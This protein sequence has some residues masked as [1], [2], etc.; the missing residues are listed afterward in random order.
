MT[1]NPALESRELLEGFAE[2]A[3]SSLRELPVQLEGYLAQPQEAE[4]L[5]AVFRVVHSIKGNAGFFGFTAI[6]TFAHAV[7]NALDDVRKQKVKLTAEL[8]R[9]FVES[10]DQ[11]EGLVNGTLDGADT[12]QLDPTQQALLARV[13]ELATESAPDTPES[14]IAAQLTQLAEAIAELDASD[15][16]RVAQRAEAMAEQCRQGRMGDPL[17]REPEGHAE[18]ATASPNAL[19]LATAEFRAG[20]R[21]WT[22]LVRPTLEVFLAMS[23]G[24]FDAPLAQAFLAA[25][26]QLAAEAEQAGLVP[27]AT[28][29]TAA[30]ADF[31]KIYQSPLGMDA[32]LLSIVWDHLCPEYVKLS[33]GA[34]GPVPA[35]TPATTA[36]E[37]APGGATPQTASQTAAGEPAQAAG[38]S[39]DK[40]S[41]RTRFVRVKEDRLDEFRGHV[42]SL[43]ITCELLKDLHSRF[44]RGETLGLLVDEMRQV[45][46]T[47]AAQTQKLQ[48]S[49]VAL[50][51]VSVSGLFAKFPRMARTLATQLG[52]QIDVHLVGEETEVDK[53]LVEDLD[54]PLTHMI[55]NVVDHGIEPPAERTQRGASASGNL[56]LRAE[57]TR[58]HVIIT[59]QDDG[60][61]IDPVRLKAKSVAKGALTQAQADAMSDEEA[62]G[63]IFAP[64]FST[65]EK[66]SEVSGRGV[67]LDVVRTKI[68]EHNGEVT[69]RS[70]VGEGTTFRLEIP[71]R[72]A[73]VVTD[74]LMIRHAQQA[75]V[76]PFEH[77][78]EIAELGPTDLSP[79]QGSQVATIRG[80]SYDAV[81]MGRILDLPDHPPNDSTRLAVLVESKLGKLC[82]LVDAVTGHRQVVVNSVADLLPG[83]DYLSGV[84][85]LGGGHLAL[86]LS[87]EELI[88]RLLSRAGVDHCR[89]Q[90][91]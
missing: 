2:E 40:H 24:R 74:G 26:D 79:V 85:Q 37:L 78:R 19:S 91:R 62:V 25:A 80:V 32:T 63:L 60:R 35:P 16:P 57:A 69:V 50:Q 41:N 90:T 76:I 46:Y 55:R 3:L 77:V 84:A 42:S 71:L 14:R 34:P 88:R 27:L 68:R 61:G 39:D 48:S 12:Q 73:V 6:K 8:A 70:A 83:L 54:A 13:A 86:V 17:D 29:A 23:Q 44:T 89:D 20:E 7:E 66:I 21:D 65:A 53:S 75:F 22:P 18:A 43:F 38:G 15:A 30:R 82:L 36:A 51:Q 72:Q 11:L 47:L 58:T 87:V 1:N 64:G 9:A 67:G 5:N 49:V 28:A 81:P 4:P 56:W 10:F 45:N 31:A 33:G 59:V 52:K